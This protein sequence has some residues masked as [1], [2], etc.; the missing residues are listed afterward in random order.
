MKQKQ[1]WS[2]YS[3][4]MVIIVIALGYFVIAPWIADI[5]DLNI[6]IAAKDR[7]NTQLEQNLLALKNLK[8]QFDESSEA[9]KLLDL[10]LPESDYLAEVVETLRGIADKSAANLIQIRQGTSADKKATD[11]EINFE[12]SYESLRMLLDNIEKNIRF[13]NINSI[14]LT[15]A[16]NIEG[17]E[18]YL[19]SNLTLSFFKVG[20]S[21]SK[22]ATPS[23]QAQEN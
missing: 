5:K 9:T 13:A 14:N 20:T 1:N 8:K 12:G 22:T 10:A 2:I 11:I 18:V 7:E 3:L 6:K 15:S 16:K 4:L 17:G 19:K 21:E 23:D